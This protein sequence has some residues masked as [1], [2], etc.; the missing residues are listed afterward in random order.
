LLRRQV[1][2]FCLTRRDDFLRRGQLAWSNLRVATPAENLP[3]AKRTGDP[4]SSR[5]IEPNAPADGDEDESAARL[6]YLRRAMVDHDR[7]LNQEWG[8]FFAQR[9]GQDQEPKSAE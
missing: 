5:P 3:E 2:K 9:K 1:G 7:R 4:F 8:E 6:A